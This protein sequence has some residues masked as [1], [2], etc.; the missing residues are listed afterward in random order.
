[1][2]DVQKPVEETPVAVPA[3]AVEPVEAPAATEPVVEAPK[4]E[5]NEAAAVTE[6]TAVPEATEPTEEVKEEVKPATEG[7]LGH[8]AP[9][10]VK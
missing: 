4:E 9:G 3:P 1:M 7:T 5:V 6:P 2:S 8:K 10:L